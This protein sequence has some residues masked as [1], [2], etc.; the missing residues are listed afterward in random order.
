MPGKVKACWGSAAAAP[1]LDEKAKVSAADTTTDYLNSKI[2]A[3]TGISKTILN[4]GAN[5]TLSIA[6]TIT[7][8]DIKAKV[9]AADTTTDYLNNKITVG[10]GLSKAIVNPGA[11]EALH[12]TASAPSLGSS[13]LHSAFL[14]CR[15]GDPNGTPEEEIV[16]G[17]GFPGYE[18]YLYVKFVEDQ[19]YNSYQWIHA[20]PKNW[21]ITTNIKCRLYWFVTNEGS[22]GT[23]V[24]WQ[25][26]IRAIGNG[27][28]LAYN[29][30]WVDNADVD[31]AN[32]VLYITDEVSITPEKAGSL[33]VCDLL[34]ITV[35]RNQDDA[36]G[37]AMLLGI[38]IQWEIDPTISV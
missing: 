26:S 12:I 34:S 27:E 13:V 7:D 10:A 15:M 6:C 29:H 4:P 14:N 35:R 2:V 16:F 37:S 36:S 11:N 1:S 3:G 31:A 23:D 25:I 17:S 22:H 30:A 24:E 38:L 28:A 5:E 19:D 33:A 8:T 21:K 9:S 20:L 18:E 32:D